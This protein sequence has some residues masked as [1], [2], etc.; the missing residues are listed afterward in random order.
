MRRCSDAASWHKGLR[1]K[2]S[3]NGTEWRWLLVFTVTR[4]AI[5]VCRNFIETVSLSPNFVFFIFS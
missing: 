3:T 5:R 4:Y 1:V 2:Q